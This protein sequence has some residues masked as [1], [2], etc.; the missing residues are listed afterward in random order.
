MHA[1]GA[2]SVTEDDS[3]IL[4]NHSSFWLLNFRRLCDILWFW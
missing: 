2:T 3:H 1:A 4:T